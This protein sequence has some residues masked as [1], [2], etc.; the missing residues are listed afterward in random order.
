MHQLSQ[1]EKDSVPEEVRK[2]AR[3]M[4]EKAF[5]D[6]WARPTNQSTV[7]PTLNRSLQKQAACSL[8]KISLH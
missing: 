4:G 7:A 6:R 2:A 8:W 3:E 1:A 5:K